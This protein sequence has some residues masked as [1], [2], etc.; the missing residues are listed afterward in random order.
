M[1]HVDSPTS[2]GDFLSLY[3][4]PRSEH[5]D[6]LFL[7]GLKS[8]NIWYGHEAAACWMQKELPPGF[9]FASHLAQSYDDSGWCYVEAI[10]SSGLKIGKQRLDLSKRTEDAIAYG[11][12]LPPTWMLQSVC[13][14]ARQPPLLPKDMRTHLKSKKFTSPAD[15]EIV[16]QLY[17]SFFDGAVATAL[18][19]DFSGLAWGVL[20]VEQLLLVLPYCAALMELDLSNNK[21][22]ASGA[23]AL[24]QHLPTAA[25][26]LTSLK[27]ARVP[28]V[29]LTCFDGGP[30]FV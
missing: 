18:G 25:K 15:I 28:S 8:S 11:G 30:Q 21:L 3:Q 29:F 12:Q 14:S 26:K 4:Q 20:E 19:L 13:A 2:A 5:E 22:G 10:I 9:S 7:P 16:Y 17:L 1:V 27:C 24:A 6:K 23:A